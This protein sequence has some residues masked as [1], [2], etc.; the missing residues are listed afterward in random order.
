MMTRTQQRWPALGFFSWKL[1]SCSPA[2]TIQYIY[3]Y[4]QTEHWTEAYHNS[5]KKEQNKSGQNPTAMRI[6]DVGF[7]IYFQDGADVQ[8]P[9]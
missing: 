7:C 4:R 6:W 5:K 9:T 2:E 1:W 8:K 3:I